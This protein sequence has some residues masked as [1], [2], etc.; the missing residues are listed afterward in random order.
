MNKADAQKEREPPRVSVVIPTRQRRDAVRRALE[1]LGAQTVP[2]DAYEVV[3]SV[4][5]S[6]DGTGEMLERLDV[7]FT[8]QVAA[9][10]ARGRAAACNA[11][12]AVARGDVVILL[13]DDMQA[14]PEFIERHRAHHL[15]STRR[16]VMGG[17]PVRLD[18]RSPLAARHVAA[19]F[20]AHSD[21]IARPGHVFVPRDFYSGNASVRADV[22][23][24]V[25]RFDESFG[26]YGN[27]DVELGV[28]LR[29]AGVELHFDPAAMAHQASEKDLRGLALD[30][31]AKGQTTVLLARAHPEIFDDL[32]L[33]QPRDASRPWLA[34]RAV[35]LALTR[36]ASGTAETVFAGAGVL[37]RLGLWRQPLFYRALLDYAFWVGVDEALSGR[38]DQGPLDQLHAELHRGPIDLLLHR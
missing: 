20:K 15:D 13:D 11:G 6:T 26:V 2:S 29:R 30:N 37:E 38:V 25:G 17:V 31:V 32:R 19:R 7:P 16:C 27:E 24:E 14:V 8:L 35:L 22:L 21:T 5:G 36:L 3:V 10:P 28:R 34:A 33:A 4:D 23:R 1:S 9:A 12:L 18:E